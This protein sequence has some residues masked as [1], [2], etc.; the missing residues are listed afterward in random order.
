MEKRKWNLLLASTVLTAGLL[1]GCGADSKPP[2]PSAEPQATQTPKG[3]DKEETDSKSKVEG[4]ELKSQDES[5][6]ITVPSDW[7][8]N[9]TLNPQAI[10][11]A[12]NLRKE[13]YVIAVPFA[14]SEFADSTTLD[15]FISVTNSNIELTATKMEVG[16]IK[17]V[18]ID[19]VSAKQT[20]IAAEVSGIQVRYLITYLEKGNRFYQL[21]AWTLDERYDEY[22]KEFSNVINSFRILNENP[23]TAAVENSNSK[24][25]LKKVTLTDDEDWTEITLPGGWSQIHGLNEEASLQASYITNASENYM[26][27][28]S[29]PKED[30]EEGHTLSD[31]YDLIMEMQLTDEVIGNS[32]YTDA[33]EL[34]INGLPAVQFEVRGEV[35][36][37]KIAYLFTLVESESGFHQLIFWTNDQKLDENKQTYLDAINTFKVKE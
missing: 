21:A 1:T 7:K 14:K 28:L 12:A 31:Y 9:S 16:E 35:D 26:V 20:V 19:D 37:V 18:Q 3:A 30:F 4:K 2:A 24:K 36:K 11:G 8:E 6:Q 23:D 33:V 29:E 10:L 34:E 13:K 15:D 5:V 17:E 22:E 25:N 27:V 32:N